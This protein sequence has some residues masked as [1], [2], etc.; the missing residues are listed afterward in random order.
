[1]DIRMYNLY[2]ICP[3][4]QICLTL[5]NSTCCVILLTC[6]VTDTTSNRCRTVIS[7][8]IFDASYSSTFECDLEIGIAAFPS[9]F[10]QPHQSG[11]YV[12]T[13]YFLYF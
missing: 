4:L 2:C 3:Y 5:I 10:Y 8:E 11:Y 9:S 13:W 1:M 6:T 7:M 12:S